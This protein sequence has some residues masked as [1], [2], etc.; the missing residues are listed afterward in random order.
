MVHDNFRASSTRQLLLGYQRVI[1]T[2]MLGPVAQISCVSLLD[3]RRFQPTF[4][5]RHRPAL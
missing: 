4:E 2:G 1:I 5:R 3:N